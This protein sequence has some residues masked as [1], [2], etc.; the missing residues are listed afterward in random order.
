MFGV[1]P[2]ALIDRASRFADNPR[3]SRG[4]RGDQFP[5]IGGRPPGNAYGMESSR[6]PFAASRPNPS[7]WGSQEKELI[8]APVPSPVPPI[9][10]IPLTPVVSPRATDRA[11]ILQRLQQGITR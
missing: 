2:D 1:R 3:L 9:G 4:W 6:F 11:S 5:M 10:R 8:P 7:S